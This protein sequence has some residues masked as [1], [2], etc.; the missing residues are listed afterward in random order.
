MIRSLARRI[1][2]ICGERGATATE[3]ALL[4]GFIAVAIVVGVTAFGDQLNN[5]YQG[6]SAKLPK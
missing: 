1:R 6:T 5:W 4:V 2:L 3:Y